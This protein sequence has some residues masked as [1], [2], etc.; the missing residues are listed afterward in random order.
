MEKEELKKQ[1]ESLGKTQAEQA[2]ALGIT[3]RQI[4]H[5]YKGERKPSKTL[6]LLIKQLKKS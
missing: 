2:E 5:F 1:I 3:A 4:R 6:L